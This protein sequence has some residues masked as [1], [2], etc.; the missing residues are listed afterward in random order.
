MQGQTSNLTLRK[1][2]A[3]SHTTANFVRKHYISAKIRYILLILQIRPYSPQNSVPLLLSLRREKTLLNSTLSYHERH[4][5]RKW[6]RAEIKI[7]EVCTLTIEPSGVVLLLVEQLAKNYD[8]TRIC[9]T[10]KTFQEH[11]VRTVGPHT[12]CLC[13]R[14]QQR[15]LPQSQSL[16]S[17]SHI[18]GVESQGFEYYAGII[19]SVID[20]S[21]HRAL[22]RHNLVIFNHHRITPSGDSIQ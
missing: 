18:A 2:L 6:P 22:R 11:R 19:S 15:H 10:I 9:I 21:K 4:L 14:M 7:P 13:C 17:G 1:I 8:N 12:L 16:R 5:D 3:T 20:P